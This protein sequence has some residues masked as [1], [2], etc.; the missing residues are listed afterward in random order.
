MQYAEVVLTVWMIIFVVRILWHQLWFLHFAAVRCCA[1]VHATHLPR[2]NTRDILIPGV[3]VLVPRTLPRAML[4]AG[5]Q[6]AT[7]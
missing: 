1:S 4:L 3:A 5:L 7:S 2:T 6:P